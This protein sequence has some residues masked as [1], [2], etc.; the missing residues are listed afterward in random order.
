MKYEREKWILN[1]GKERISDEIKK[2]KS[3]Y[4]KKRAKRKRGGKK[5]TKN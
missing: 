4:F 2:R 5:L 1:K 3:V